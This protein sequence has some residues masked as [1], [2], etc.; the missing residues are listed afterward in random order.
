M[1]L[2]KFGRFKKIIY[3]IKTGKYIGAEIL[4][5]QREHLD[6]TPKR[7]VMIML[8]KEH[9]AVIYCRVIKMK[10]VEACCNHDRLKFLIR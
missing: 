9:L 7:I 4:V 5:K 10:I 6:S 3:P 1:S 8:I 2:K